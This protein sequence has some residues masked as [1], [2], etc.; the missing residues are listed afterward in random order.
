MRRYSAALGGAALLLL[1]GAAVAPHTARAQDAKP[2]KPVS[3]TFDLGFVNAAGNTRVTTLN[4]AENLKFRPAESRWQ[5]AE[6]VSTVYGRSQDSVT[7]EQFTALGRADYTV[8]TRLHLFAGGTYLRDRFAGIARRIEEIGGVA[9]RLVDRPRDVL[10]TEVG[11]A[12]TQQRS[13]AGVE[14][15]FVALRVAANYK[16]NL[17]D[18]AFVQQS[19]EWLPN[20]QDFKDTRINSETA[21]IAPITK[22]I[23]VR[24]SY[25]VRFDN[26]PEPGF[27][28]TDRVLSSGVQIAL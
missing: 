27:L 10:G 19:L 9:L 23:A 22:Q 16:H 11:A 17:N 1:G 7:A 15:N 25:V 5:F 18:N 8:L 24:L 21:L 12:V 3:V 28:K 20:V 14:D 26:V 13:T 6:A 2:A 4:G